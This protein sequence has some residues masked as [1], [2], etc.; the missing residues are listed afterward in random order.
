MAIYRYIYFTILS[1]YKRF[2]RD[3]QINIFAVGLF[4]IFIFFL[5]L[6]LF[7]VYQYFISHIYNLNF[8]YMI[9]L[10]G[11]IFLFLVVKGK[12]NIMKNIVDKRIKWLQY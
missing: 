3:P 11:L 5:I 2:S 1:V 6:S 8:L 4:S 10:A 12:K 7:D 9:G